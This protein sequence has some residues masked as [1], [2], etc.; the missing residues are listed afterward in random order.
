MESS[1]RD[2][3][4]WYGE[5]LPAKKNAQKI[6]C[7]NASSCTKDV[8]SLK[9][10]RMKCP[11]GHKTRNYVSQVSFMCPV[12]VPGIKAAESSLFSLVNPF[13]AHFWYG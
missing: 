1:G 6:W 3:Y 5:K 4:T 13:A 2:A 12:P 11:L 8:L 7:K 10:K 9:I